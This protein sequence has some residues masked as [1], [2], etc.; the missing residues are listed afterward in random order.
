[1]CLVTFQKKTP[2][3]EK[4][5]NLFFNLSVFLLGRMFWIFD[6]CWT[7]TTVISIM[8]STKIV[9]EDPESHPAWNESDFVVRETEGS[10]EED[11]TE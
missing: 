2:C 5:I 3:P 7:F 4:N 1:M 8:S 10:G 9:A 6:L 11:E